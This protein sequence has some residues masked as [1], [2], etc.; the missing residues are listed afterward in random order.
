M[1]YCIKNRIRSEF[2]KN[3]VTLFSGTALAQSI[4]ILV[5]PL[6]TRLYKPSDYGIMAVFVAITSIIIIASTLRYEIAIL[7]PED[8]HDA[9]SVTILSMLCVFFFSSVVLFIILAAQNIILN[10]LYIPFPWMYAI[11]L[12]VIFGGWSAS[13]NYWLNR[14]KQFRKLAFNRIVVAVAT[15]FSTLAFGIFA[16]SYHGLI[17]GILLGQAFSLALFL[18]WT[19]HELVDGLSSKKIWNSIKFNA[20]KYFKFPLFS[21]PADWI[22]ALSQQLPVFMMS[23]FFGA[24]VVGH[25]SFSQR[26]LGAPLNLLSKAV[27]DTFKQRASS[28]YN[29]H[30]NC[31]KIFN[32]TFKALTVLSVFPLLSIFFLAP[33]IFKIVFGSEWEQAGQYT[34]YLVP[35]Y[36]FR[37]ISSPLSFVSII[38][39]RQD[40]DLAWQIALLI[41]TLVSMFLGAWQQNSDLAIICFSFLYSVLYVIYFFIAGKL[42]RGV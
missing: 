15:S 35:L 17:A 41:S 11:P 9:M 29:K 5:T 22:N 4:P 10:F 23:K 13:L 39:N 30:G 12:S 6:L 28:D 18:I 19:W 32:N 33:S 24:A 14:H 1:M 8:D 26:I 38:A 27:G 21:L 42:S 16:F 36:F 3:V 31:S 7:M 34:R 20:Y 25:F 2:A 37:F 40:L